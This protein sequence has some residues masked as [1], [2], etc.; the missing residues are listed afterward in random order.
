MMAN[1]KTVGLAAFL[2][3]SSNPVDKMPGCA[4]FDQHYGGCLLGDNCLIQDSKRCGHFEKTVLPTAADIRSGERI[5][6]LYE[7]QCGISGTLQRDQMRI[8]PDCGT[9]LKPRQRYCDG[10]ANKRRRQS[11]RNSRSKRNR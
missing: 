10:C 4:N 11:Y 6:S 3:G 1:R 7:K 2:K 9:G 5:Y 8:C